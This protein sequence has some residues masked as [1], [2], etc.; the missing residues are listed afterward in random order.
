M[1]DPEYPEHDKLSAIANQSQAC[2]DFLEWLSYKKGWHLGSHTY[3]ID[4]VTGRHIESGSYTDH[5][6]LYPEEEVTEFGVEKIE[7]GDFMIQVPYSIRDLLAEFFE[8]DQNRLEAEK[9]AML[10]ALRAANTAP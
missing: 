3:Y 10:D 6:M 5:G 9:R 7:N 8:I 2:H 1:P 4:V